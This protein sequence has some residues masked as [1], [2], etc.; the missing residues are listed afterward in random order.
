MAKKIV[1]ESQIETNKRKAKEA[2]ARL[3]KLFKELSKDKEWQNLINKRKKERIIEAQ[4]SKKDND[5]LKKL[6]K[7]QKH[8]NL[9][10]QSQAQEKWYSEDKEWNNLI[11]QRNSQGLNFNKKLELSVYFLSFVILVLLITLYWIL[12]KKNDK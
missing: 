10:K 12:K 7:E 2:N 6:E 1:G 11:E 4:Q 9:V 8:S 3:D 5:V